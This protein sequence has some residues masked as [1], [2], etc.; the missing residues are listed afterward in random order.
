MQARR[1]E[2]KWGGA[3]CKNVEN[4]GVLLKK[5]GKWRCFCKK[6]KIWGLFCKKWTFSQRSISI[7]YFTFY[8]FGG[9][10]AYAPNAPPPAAYGPASAHD[11]QA[12]S[13][14]GLFAAAQFP[15]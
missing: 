13:P 10:G 1:Q 15:Q 14:A 4:G 6:W 5:S 12:D 3:F 9:G 7:F 11:D 2:M 8:L